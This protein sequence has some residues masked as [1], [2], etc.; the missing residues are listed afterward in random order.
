M[1]PLLIC[2]TWSWNT[3]SGTYYEETDES[4]M[5]EGGLSR[6]IVILASQKCWVPIPVVCQPVHGGKCQRN[7][8]H[9]IKILLC[10]KVKCC[11]EVKKF[12]EIFK[13]HCHLARMLPIDLSQALQLTDNQLGYDKLI[14]L[15]TD[16]FRNKNKV[17]PVKVLIDPLDHTE[18]PLLQIQPDLM[19][20]AKFLK[21]TR[22]SSLQH[23]RSL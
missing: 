1:Y 15:W 7:I 3:G 13:C 17:E 21:K 8:V 14:R 5:S 12:E 10:K 18:V 20:S 19:P 9:S 4:S 2:C 16:F 23:S 11:E 22:L 6:R